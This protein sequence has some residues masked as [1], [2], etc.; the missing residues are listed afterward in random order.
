MPYVTS[1]ERIANEEGRQQ[2]LQEGLQEGRQEGLQQGAYQTAIQ[3]V[4]RLLTR[5]FGEIDK[6]TQARI[7]TLRLEQL[8]QLGEALLDFTTPED[9]QTWLHQHAPPP[10]PPT[11][12]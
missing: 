2:G 6:A 12:N 11:S 3:L 4:L 10:V 9:L 1:I 7:R 8:E 5:L